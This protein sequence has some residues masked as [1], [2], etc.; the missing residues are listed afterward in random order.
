MKIHVE[1]TVALANYTY[2]ETNAK[3]NYYETS[4][5]HARS[6]KKVQLVSKTSC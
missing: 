2:L 5:L 4:L 1:A 3:C 6:L